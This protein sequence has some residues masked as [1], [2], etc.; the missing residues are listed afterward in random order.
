MN[1]HNRSNINF[2][3][4]DFIAGIS[5]AALSLP[6]G[7][8]YAEIVGL[9]PESGIYTAIFSLICY[10]ILGSSK[11]LI[12]G[13][14]SATCTVFATTIFALSAGNN[15]LIPQYAVI[16][17][18]MTG[19]LFFVAGFLKLGFIS[20]FLS[21]P[22]LIG[23]LNGVSIILIISQLG[24]F[25]GI[26]LEKST[27]IAGLFE[28]IDKAG[29]T[30]LPTLITGIV[31]LILLYFLKKISFKI[32]AQLI[33]LVISIICVQYLGLDSFGIKLTKEIKDAFPSFIIP[34]VNLFFE[35]FPSILIHSAALLFVSYSGEI[36][37]VQSFTKNKSG[38]DPNKEFFALGLAGIVAGF[39]KGF[40]VSGADSRT[41]VNVAVGGKT[42]MVNI[43]AAMIM[44]L[45]IIFLS[46][47]F[48]LVPS[49]IFGA[50]IINAA[51]GMFK[52]NELIRIRNF[53]RKEF[54]VTMICIMGVLTIGVLDGIL[55]ALV[56]SFIQLIG[57][58]SKPDES[59]L[60]YDNEIEAAVDINDKNKSFIKEDILIYKFNSALL[61]YNSNYFKQKILERA[62]SKK[63]LKLIIIDARPVNNIDLTAM[64]ILTEV[65]KEFNNKN[66][67]V[68]FVGVEENVF[69]VL[70]KEI[71]LNNLNK[72]IFYPSVR[73]V[74][75]DKC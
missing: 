12:I 45:V 73:S 16:I 42:K 20:N 13:P 57:K 9:P 3:K 69:T 23:Y 62:N 43:F 14:D 11:E 49:V 15:Y 25:T 64:N 31:S 46:G 56:L 28:F 19:I 75:L 33:L 18:I 74:I 40:I 50:I 26:N 22:I 55:V 4:G 65:V 54:R 63:D 61:F 27:S 17:S 52:F 29:M 21:K 60:V 58:S 6:V 66:I 39:F 53:S 32:P 38:F 37:V 5:V 72:N 44:L 8:A 67:P 70:E 7:V 47:E 68:Y 34:D 51:F 2:L 48:A 36:P 10:Y 41:A 71:E 59:E 24:K 1:S 30:H 35:K